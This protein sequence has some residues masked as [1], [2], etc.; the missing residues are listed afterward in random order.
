M[1]RGEATGNSRAEDALAAAAKKRT[2]SPSV[3]QLGPQ[4]AKG[5]A[6]RLAPLRVSTAQRAV[7]L[8]MDLHREPMRAREIRQIRVG[9]IEVGLRRQ[10][11]WE[12]DSGSSRERL[13]VV[14]EVVPTPQ[15]EEVLEGVL[16]ARVEPLVVVRGMAELSGDHD[17]VVRTLHEIHG[18]ADPEQ[19]GQLTR[20][21]WIDI[22]ELGPHV[23]DF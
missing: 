5:A 17:P 8:E 20:A 15:E 12:V 9:V 16:G 22:A 4:C 23:R 1:S 6:V 14:A 19:D 21:R 10:R 7:R 18:R 3:T 11:G 13:D 2:A